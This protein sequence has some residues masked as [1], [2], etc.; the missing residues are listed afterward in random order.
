MSLDPSTFNHIADHDMSKVWNR[1][2]IDFQ[3]KAI[4]R[5][6]MMR[7][8]PNIPRGLLLVQGNGA[9]KYTVSQTVGLLDFDMALV[10]KETLALAADQQSKVFALQIACMDLFWCIN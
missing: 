6:L 7:C 1:T 10:I 2:P 8:V 4:P 9:G 3:R 5:L